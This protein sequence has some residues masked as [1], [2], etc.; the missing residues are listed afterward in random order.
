[1]QVVN[2]DPVFAHV[3]KYLYALAAFKGVVNVAHKRKQKDPPALP[4]SQQPV[5]ASASSAPSSQPAVH[6]IA[7]PTATA[8]A[9]PQQANG[10]HHPLLAPAPANQ[11]QLA[12][13]ALASNVAA[14]I[15]MPTGTLAHSATP[16]TLIANLAAAPPA[17]RDVLMATLLQQRLP[18][19]FAASFAAPAAAQA[20]P[21]TDAG[22]SAPARAPVPG[23]SGGQ[24]AGSGA[25]QEPFNAPTQ[26]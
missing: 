25:A 26:L 12:A 24:L 6:P 19:Q 1:M 10:S 21:T 20:A 8:N 9:G 16:N 11:G 13:A 2:G 7:Q 23:G 15:G 22:K 18:Q 3:G 14:M 5:P 4:A 17:M